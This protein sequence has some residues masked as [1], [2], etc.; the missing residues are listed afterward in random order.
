MYPRLCDDKKKSIFS[1]MIKAW[2]IK[3]IFAVSHCFSVILTGM[4]KLAKE[5]KL[6]PAG[7]ASSG[8]GQGLAG[9][10]IS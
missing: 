9:E 2:K 3:D 4:N 8:L 5:T 6:T 10:A 1:G 7:P